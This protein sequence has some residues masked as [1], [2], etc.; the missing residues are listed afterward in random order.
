MVLQ[1]V[2]L[3]RLHI[4]VICAALEYDRF[5]PGGGGREREDGKGEGMK[6]H[7]VKI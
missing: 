5:S 6:G 2:N 7:Y 3:K 4:V 1:D